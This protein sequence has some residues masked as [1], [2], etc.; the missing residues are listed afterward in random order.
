LIKDLDVLGKEDRDDNVFRKLWE[1]LAGTVGQVF[2][3]HPKDQVATKVPFEGNIKDPSSNIWYTI[4]ELL[5]NAF[6]RA[7][8]PSIDNQI[9]IASV[10]NEKEEKPKFLEKIFG[11][12]KQD[13][14]NKKK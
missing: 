4:S 7:I 2:K 8:Q 14:D 5:T 1:G 11:K 13:K 9:S 12:K 3:N 10:G 6:I